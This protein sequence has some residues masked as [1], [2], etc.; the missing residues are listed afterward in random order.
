[1]NR[2]EA[3]DEK[4]RVSHY[5]R[6]EKAIKV[7]GST[8]R[9]FQ[10]DLTNEPRS[11][12]KFF[13]DLESLMHE[14]RPDLDL[15]PGLHDFHLQL[16]NER[17]PTKGWYGIVAF[18]KADQ[19]L[20]GPVAASVCMSCDMDCPLSLGCLGDNCEV[21]PARSTTDLLVLPDSMLS[22]AIVACWNMEC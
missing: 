8:V 18:N 2:A 5:S 20:P 14:G 21:Q 19:T 15:P 12:V 4:T 22:R 11:I 3:L 13:R 16:R 1:M 10:S 9:G 7:G 17:Y 6:W